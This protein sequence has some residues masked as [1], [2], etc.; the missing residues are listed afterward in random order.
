MLFMITFK[1]NPHTLRVTPSAK[2]PGRFDWSITRDAV[3]V[4]QSARSFGSEGASEANGDA[5][6]RELTSLWQNAR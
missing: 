4:R 1:P 3:V 2:E 6:F 5:A